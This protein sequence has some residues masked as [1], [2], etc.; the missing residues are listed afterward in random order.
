MEQTNATRYQIQCGR[1]N[2]SWMGLRA[3]RREEDE[4]LSGNVAARI[5]T[6]DASYGSGANE[7]KQRS[8]AGIRNQ[9][10][11]GR[12][13]TLERRLHDRPRPK[14]MRRAHVDLW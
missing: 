10:P 9:W 2:S 4:I 6:R 1:P 3:G 13:S 5:V 14:P 7:R 12:G 8:A 11:R